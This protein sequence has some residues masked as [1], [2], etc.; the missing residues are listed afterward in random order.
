[1]NC[2][3][4]NFTWSIGHNKALLVPDSCRGNSI[5]TEMIQYILRTVISTF[6]SSL[7]S[8]YWQLQLTL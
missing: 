7:F 2:I 3:I 5:S 6:V 4:F 8:K 1:M